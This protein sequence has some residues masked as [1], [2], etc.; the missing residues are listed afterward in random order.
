M[1]NIS[2][3]PGVL[4]PCAA[5]PKLAKLPSEV[6]E[7]GAAVVSAQ[8]CPYLHAAY[9]PTLPLHMDSVIVDQ[10]VTVEFVRFLSA[11]LKESRE[12]VDALDQ[13]NVALKSQLQKLASYITSPATAQDAHKVSE[14]QGAVASLTEKL[15]AS[16]ATVEQQ[17]ME[18]ALW[19]T[20]YDAV[21]QLKTTAA[22]Q[23]IRNL[24][25]HAT[26]QKLL[27]TMRGELAN[28][29]SLAASATVSECEEFK[30]F[31][32]KLG[33]SS[34]A[35]EDNDRES[36]IVFDLP[37][38]QILPKAAVKACGGKFDHFA[39]LVE[40]CAAPSRNALLF[41]PE[42]LYDPSAASAGRPPW[43]ETTEWSSL[44]GQHHELFAV[45]DGKLAYV[46]TFLFHAG[47]AALAL[48]ELP[49]ASNNDLIEELARRTF[50]P[51]SKSQHAKAKAY[52]PALAELYRQ[53]AARVRVL[54]LQRI[55][56]NDVFFQVLRK[57]YAKRG[58]QA[59]HKAKGA[60][61]S[62]EAEQREETET[63]RSTS[64]VAEGV[65]G[66]KRARGLEEGAAGGGRGEGLGKVAR[67]DG[68]KR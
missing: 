7:Q 58:K 22:I 30:L 49:A 51:E 15:G 57:A 64:P 52:L 63:E 11:Q 33:T 16:Q 6:N 31:M 47:P 59:A 21:Q 66:K 60:H 65:V 34:S 8:R 17:S 44:V 26:T 32:S 27:A 39:G 23:S 25:K 61:V 24:Q 19:R 28:A 10:E 18:I 67:V 35:T 29:P 40:W 9:T 38:L 54:G 36:R 53:G 1:R 42:R 48:P 12:Q 68:F 62:H 55:G 50:R 37:K 3:M 43:A 56:F 45:E 20:R 13:E 2:E 14:L 4:I 46:G 5:E 41:C